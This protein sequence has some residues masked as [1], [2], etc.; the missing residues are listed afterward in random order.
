MHPHVPA[1]L[2]TMQAKHR[3]DAEAWARQADAAALRAKQGERREAQLEARLKQ[4]AAEMD[5]LRAKLRNGLVSKGGRGGAAEDGGGLAALSATAPAGF[6]GQRAASA[7]ARG[8]GADS[9]KLQ[10]VRPAR[11]AHVGVRALQVR[12]SALRHCY[13]RRC[14]LPRHHPAACAPAAP[15]RLRGQ[16]C[17]SRS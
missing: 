11:G 6:A 1:Q 7:G 8:G 16:G 14:A 4:Q 3:A 12:A 10:K 2:R 9:Q 13:S 5:A 15:G 17:C